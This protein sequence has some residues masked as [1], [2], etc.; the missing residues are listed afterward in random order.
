MLS[1][2]SSVAFDNSDGGAAGRRNQLLYSWLTAIIT[3]IT[4]GTYFTGLML[5]FGADEKYIS[6]ITAITSL[7]GIAQLFS[8]M[9]L[10]KFKRR[11]PL[12]ISLRAVYHIIFTGVLAVIPILPISKNAV[13]TLFLISFL[14][15]NLI[16]SITSSGISVWHIQNV[17]DDKFSNYFTMIH[18]GTQLIGCTMA[19][20][21]GVVV[22]HYT[23]GAESGAG[24]PYTA[25][26]I[27]RAFAL[28][29]GAIEICTML[30]IK[31]APY[32]H[33]DNERLNLRLLLL[34]VRS[35]RYLKVCFI[36]FTYVLAANLLGS[37]Y[38]IY[39]LDV[40]KI[41]YTFI[42]LCD[43]ISLPV[44]LIAAPIWSKLVNRYSWKKILPINI[45]GIGFGW[46]FCMFVTATTPYYYF[47]TTI[48]YKLF[49]PSAAS[50]F[51]YMP[52]KYMPEEN[53]TAY[54]SFYASL[55]LV[56]A[57]FG[58]L[59]GMLFM[60]LTSGV[61]LNL[62]GT[63]FLNYQYI[64]AFQFS[65]FACVTVYALFTLKDKN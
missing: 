58:N 33:K 4:T 1:G 51:A 12:L 36:Y 29:V 16:N 55:A 41:D 22:D 10:E 56:F 15:A 53:K 37:Y 47:I 49:Y 54:F 46:I 14:I 43:F 18:M 62:F 63:T 40:C 32:K 64:T 24:T 17:P 13:L 19:I 34:P 42:S 9:L 25:F 11:K 38:S 3:A 44:M 28:V 60:T 39:M 8:P 7:C 45:F 26:L 30:R 59:I 50:I 31:E 52:Y 27:L 6:V 35:K 21:A 5:Y 65:V 61:T 57:F 20:F 2:V 48:V 23:S